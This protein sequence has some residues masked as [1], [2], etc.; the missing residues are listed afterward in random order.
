MGRSGE[1]T[2]TQLIA[3]YERGKYRRLASEDAKVHRNLRP[4]LDVAIQNA[5]K[6][7]PRNIVIS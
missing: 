6:F 7:S 3:H 2:L 5:V 4:H 1:M